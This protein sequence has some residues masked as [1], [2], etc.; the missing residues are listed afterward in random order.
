MIFPWELAP[1]ANLIVLK[2][3]GIAEFDQNQPFRPN[4][5]IDLFGK[6]DREQ[7]VRLVQ[8]HLSLEANMRG[9]GFDFAFQNGPSRPG[10]TGHIWTQ[11]GPLRM[12]NLQVGCSGNATN[13]TESR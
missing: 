11:L 12:S 5:Q 3:L 9:A 8:D 6:F 13:Q 1:G 10:K 4:R 7:A 2:F